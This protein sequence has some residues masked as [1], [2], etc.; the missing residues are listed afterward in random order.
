MEKT[1]RFKLAEKISIFLTKHGRRNVNDESEWNCPDAH[2][3][4]QAALYLESNAPLAELHLPN[5]NWECG[6]YHPY[7]D[8][9]A[10]EL[11]DSIILELKKIK[12]TL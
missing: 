11:H 9:A 8:K 12:S 10:R 2:L 4:E 3:M 6:G 7:A 1:E 5:S